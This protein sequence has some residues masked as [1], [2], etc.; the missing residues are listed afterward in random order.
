M[1]TF[2]SLYLQQVSGNPVGKTPRTLQDVVARRVEL[3]SY[4]AQ[5]EIDTPFTPRIIW[6]LAWL[7]V[8]Q[9][10]LVA[11]IMPDRLVVAACNRYVQ[12]LMDFAGWLH[13]DLPNDVPEPGLLSRYFTESAEFWTELRDL[14]LRDGTPPLEWM[15]NDVTTLLWIRFCIFYS[16]ASITQQG[17]KRS[18]RELAEILA[19]A[20][21]Q[22]PNPNTLRLRTAPVIERE[23]VHADH[24][25]ALCAR[26][27][28]SAGR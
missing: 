4:A 9:V 23:L 27:P 8:R 12:H 2:L 16:C 28:T 7:S 14:L 5:T 18:R 3:D 17:R 24:W 1:S 21:D 15:D 20:V 19:N 22:A 11:T 13:R 25:A 6:R 26:R 10:Q